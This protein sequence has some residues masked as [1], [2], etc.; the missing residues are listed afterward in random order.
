MLLILEFTLSF[1]VFVFLSYED[2][3]MEFLLPITGLMITSAA[4]YHVLHF[5]HITIDIRNVCVFL[6]PLFSSFTTI[7]TYHLTKELKVKDLG[8]SRLGMNFVEPC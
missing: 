5:F 2:N 8:D 6:A 7:V 1:P 4:I 3:L